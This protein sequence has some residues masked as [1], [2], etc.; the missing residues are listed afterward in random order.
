MP[1]QGLTN[2]LSDE[3]PDETSTKLR[4]RKMHV[5]SRDRSIASDKILSWLVG[6]ADISRQRSPVSH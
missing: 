4:P 6:V 3:G 1:R 5:I 2:C